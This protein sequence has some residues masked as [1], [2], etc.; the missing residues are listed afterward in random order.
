M[1]YMGRRLFFQLLCHC[2]HCNSGI[3]TPSVD[4]LRHVFGFVRVCYT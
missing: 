2:T 1:F 3:G 4:L